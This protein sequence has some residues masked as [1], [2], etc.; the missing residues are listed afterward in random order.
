MAIISD[1]RMVRQDAPS[2]L[3]AEQSIAA[4]WRNVR[5]DF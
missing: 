2:K 4:K 3:K 1:C 5:L